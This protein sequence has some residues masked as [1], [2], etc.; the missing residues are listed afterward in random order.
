M[1]FEKHESTTHEIL[2]PITGMIKEVKAQTQS[3]NEAKPIVKHERST[4]RNHKGGGKQRENPRVTS[5]VNSNNQLDG[6]EL[7]GVKFNRVDTRVRGRGGL[8]TRSRD[9]QLHKL[10]A[11]FEPNGIRQV[12]ISSD[13]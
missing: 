6:Q 10:F 12:A 8:P 11:K 1:V 5:V 3:V 7:S 13:P 2:K 4:S 9:Q